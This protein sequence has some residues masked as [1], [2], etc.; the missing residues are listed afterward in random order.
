MPI[1]CALLLFPQEYFYPRYQGKLKLLPWLHCQTGAVSALCWADPISTLPLGG[2]RC[3]VRAVGSTRVKTWVWDFLFFVCLYYHFIPSCLS[4]R[5]TLL[6]S[7]TFFDS[8]PCPHEEV[9][10]T[11]C[12]QTFWSQDFWDYWGMPSS[13][14]ICSCVACFINICSIIS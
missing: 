9:W 13:Q 5:L 4:L 10:L 12:P 2:G 8:R 1:N 11:E 14:T 6:F 3:E 7:D